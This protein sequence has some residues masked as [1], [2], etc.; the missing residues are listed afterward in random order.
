MTI[1]HN[2]PKAAI[3]D[4]EFIPSGAGESGWMIYLNDNYSFDPMSPDWTRFIPSDSKREA[5]DLIVYKVS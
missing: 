1:K 2:L 3:Q 5:L 4:I